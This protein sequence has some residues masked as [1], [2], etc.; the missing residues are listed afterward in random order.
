[1]VGWVVLTAGGA[2][3]R[4]R[5]RPLADRSTAVVAAPAV[6]VAA[7][8]TLPTLGR[9]PLSWDEAVT[10]GAAERSPHQLLLML[11][12]TDAPLGLYY[13]LM[14]GWV[15]LLGELG[16]APTAGWLRLPSAAAAIG[17]VGLLVVLVR[18]WFDPATALLA[19]LLLAVHPLLTFYAQDARPYTLVTCAFLAST[20]ALLRAV[21]RPSWWRLAVYAG[22]A[23]LT[24]YLHFFS[25]YALAAQ[26]VVV[27]AARRALWRWLV[28]VL[29]VVAS[30]VPLVLVARHESGELVWIPH[31]TPGVVGA[32][33][34]HMF[35]GRALIVL[36][37]A[38]VVL[39]ARAAVRRA[40]PLEPGR[41]VRA[42]FLVSWLALPLVGLVAVDFLVPDLVARYG[43]VTIPAMVAIVAGLAVRTR[44]PAM[45]LLTVA[46]LVVAT[47]TTV[48]QELRPYKYENYRSAADVMGDLAAP[49]S[50][51][52]F[53]PMSMRAGFAPY[54]RLEPDLTKV[55][56]A[57]LETGDEP[58]STDQ[59]GGIDRPTGLLRNAFRNAPDIFVLG[60]SLAVAE[61]KLRDPAD[62]AQQSALSGYRT[63]GTYRFGVVTLTELQRVT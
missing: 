40:R 35:G 14:Q 50:A 60:D 27:L 18:R 51:V 2:L 33:L 6:A 49:G 7:A 53:L 8:I 45:R 31:P 24:L 39:G 10:F 41:R 36:M 13:L 34:E 17:A 46:A 21:A 61:Q 22:L 48:G 16:F 59:I 25:A 44:G 52:M 3:T 26:A 63:V 37:L 54:S 56:D 62:R 20:W 19:G 57:A 38:I 4:P 11:G 28:V 43:L 23:V 30:V 12:H 47:G 42:L 9:Q 32:V 5:W 1:V 29:V 15:W 55:H 58:T